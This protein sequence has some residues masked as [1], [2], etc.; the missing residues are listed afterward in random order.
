MLVE[1]FPFRT[2]F[3]KEEFQADVYHRLQAF[4]MM[5]YWMMLTLGV[6]SVR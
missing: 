1:Q 2:F 3:K 6:A 5:M 4:Y